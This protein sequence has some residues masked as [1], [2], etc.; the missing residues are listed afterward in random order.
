M[1]FEPALAQELKSI[2]ALENRIYPLNAPETSF[3]LTKPYLIYGSSEGLRTKEI[4]R[5]YRTGK[6]IRGELNVIAP[7]YSDMKSI[8]GQ[9]IDL[10]VS[11]ERRKIGTDGPFIQELTYGDPVELYENQPKLYRCVIDFEVYFDQG[12]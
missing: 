1:N 9:V 12:G 6:S 4:G 8:T 11:M 3:D 5:G 10:M 7:R 2:A